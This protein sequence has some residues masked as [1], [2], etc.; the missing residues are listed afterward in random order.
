MGEVFYRLVKSR[1]NLFNIMSRPNLALTIFN[2]RDDDAEMANKLTEEVYDT[3][4]KEGE[5]YIMSAVLSEVYAIIFVGAN[6]QAEEIF[7]RKAFR[8]FIL[9]ADEVIS[10]RIG[11]ITSKNAIS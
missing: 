3:I 9:T 8:I 5:I 4:I 6:L 7:P 11:D 2:I 10:R 1:P